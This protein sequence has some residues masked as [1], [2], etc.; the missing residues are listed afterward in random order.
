MVVKQK[1]KRNSSS[2]GYTEYFIFKTHACS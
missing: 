1:G 2:R